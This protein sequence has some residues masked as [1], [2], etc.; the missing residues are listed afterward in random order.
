[1]T[2]SA[3]NFAPHIGLNAPDDGLFVEHAGTDPLAQIRF[4]HERGFRAIED[5]FFK[6]RPV[7]VQDAIARELERLDMRLATFVAT[8]E[9]ATP[10]GVPYG[11]DALSIGSGKKSDREALVRIV[12]ESAEVAKRVGATNCTVLSG[13]FDLAVPREYQTANAIE[14][15]KRCAEVA[16]RSGL[17][18]GLEPI[19][20]REWTGTFVTTVPHAYL[21]TKAVDSPACRVIFDAYH[22]QIETGS[23]L[24]NL[25]LA[26]DQIG[27]VQIADAPGRD[28]PGTGEMNYRTILRALHER[29]YDGFVGV[30]HGKSRP[31]VEGELAVLAALD[32]VTP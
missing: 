31:G 22:V 25:D 21:I 12:E 10:I 32:A 9:T 17:V 13:P 18:L 14:N 3:M 2:R 27:Y 11:P 15:L 23:V 16:E 24:E 26:W 30:E 6:A 1:M 7:E 4:I 29:G 19:N 8:F 20:A 28:E 5:N